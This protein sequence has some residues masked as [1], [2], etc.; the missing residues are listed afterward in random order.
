MSNDNNNDND[1]LSCPCCNYNIENY[2]NVIC[3]EVI[4][5]YSG[6]ASETGYTETKEWQSG[7]VTYRSENTIEYS[8]AGLLQKSESRTR[9]GLETTYYS[10]IELQK[11]I[12]GFPLG[13]LLPVMLIGVVLIWTIK[14]KS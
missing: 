4:T 13:F 1:I 10:T 12:P 14:W 3:D 5:Y 2:I 8:L 7:G 6:E 9:T 11:D